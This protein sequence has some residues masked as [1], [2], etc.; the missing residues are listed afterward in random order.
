[1]PVSRFAT[2]RISVRLYKSIMRTT[3]DEGLSVSER[4]AGKEAFIDLTPFLGDG[5]SVTTTKGVRQPAGAFSIT[6]ADR[7]NVAGSSM[8]PAVLDASLETIYGLV[9]PMDIVEIR[10]WGGEGRCPNPMPI[11]MRGF[12]SSITRRRTMAANGQP[13]RTVVI[14]GQDYGKVLQTYQILFLPG[15]VGTS[16]LLTGYN[17]YELFGDQQ[18]NTITAADFLKVMIEKVINPMLNT[19]IP[20][21]SPMP[22]QITPDVQGVEGMLNNSYSN[23]EGSVLDLLNQ[24]LDIGIWNE[25]FIEDREDG[26]YLVLR[27]VPAYDLQ[28]GNS[29]QPLQVPAVIGTIPDN[30]IVQLEQSRDDENVYNFYWVTANRFDLVDD[31]TRRLEAFSSTPGKH[32]PTVDMMDYSNSRYDYYGTRPLYADATLAP[33]D[34]TNMSGGLQPDAQESRAGD[35]VSWIT[36]RR[37]VLNLNNK[38]NVVLEQGSMQVKGGPTRPASTELLRAGDYVEVLDGVTS[39]MGYA[40]EISDNFAPYQSYSTSIR[41][42]RGTGFAARVSESSGHSPWLSDQATRRVEDIAGSE[43]DSRLVKAT[44]WLKDPSSALNYFKG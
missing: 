13:Q 39:W 7:P 33:P 22:R 35:I 28:T 32:D 41:F 19:L 37:K 21:N 15:Y 16:P 25:L 42:D 26:V 20:P 5:S 17:M 36:D 29:T 2:P 43:V 6:F 31:M 38:D 18:R 23:T 3:S 8:G 1:M 10:M 40:F 44:E 27:P 9:E 30:D 11:K 34:V 24:H 12:V 14:S 4:Y